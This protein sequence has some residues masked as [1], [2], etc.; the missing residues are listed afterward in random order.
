MEMV[1]WINSVVSIKFN[2]KMW[3]FP[4]LSLWKWWKLNPKGRF[5]WFCFSIVWE[6]ETDRQTILT[7]IDIAIRFSH[8]VKREPDYT[9]HKAWR[10]HHLTFSNSKPI[11]WKYVLIQISSQDLPQTSGGVLCSWT[12][13]CATISNNFATIHQ[14]PTT[15]PYIK[16]QW[17]HHKVFCK[18][19]R[20]REPECGWWVWCHWSQRERRGEG[21]KKADSG[22]A[23]PTLPWLLMMRELGMEGSRELWVCVWALMGEEVFSFSLPI[24]S[25]WF[26]LG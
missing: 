25:C 6:S 24:S 26:G 7:P 5:Q 13:G 10:Y 4:L 23:P 3:M 18:W 12:C 11:V 16:C 19:G 17:N 2:P 22:A 15:N 1:N 9:I 8:K 14:V 20:K 21:K